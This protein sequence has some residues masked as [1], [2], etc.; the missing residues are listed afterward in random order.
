MAW[1]LI[2]CLIELRAEFNQLAPSRDKGADGSIGDSAHTS[3]SDHSPD[4][5][6]VHLRDHDV[7][8]KNEVHALDIDST[9]PWPN[10]RGF[11]RIVLD[12]IAGERT[13]WLSAT[14][15]CRLEYVIFNRKIYSRQR[16][17]MPVVYVG[18][19]PHT[20]HV[21][22]SGRYLTATENDTR[23]WG[24]LAPMPPDQQEDEMD[25]QEYFASIARATAVPADPNATQADRANRDAFA[26]GLR[27]ALGYN[28][29]YDQ[30]TLPGGALI[31]IADA[32]EQMAE[33]ADGSG[34]PGGS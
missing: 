15:K 21:H 31:R 20:N 6:S 30:D 26:A 16:D 14:D 2:P 11:Q 5:G 29:P 33:G 25:I 22:F 4:E 13:K 3:R 28:K 10:G 24:V 17:F 8:D 12:V 1:V 7:D 32:T 18:S 9:G 19:D 34:E 23:P 27:F